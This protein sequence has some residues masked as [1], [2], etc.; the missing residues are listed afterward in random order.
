VSTEG[1]KEKQLI[2]RLETKIGLFTVISLVILISGLLWLDGRQLLD[3][4]YQLEVAFTHV[5]GLRPGAPVQMSGVD[6][7][8][9]GRVTFTSEGQVLVVLNLTPAV[10]IKT[11]ALVTINTAG[12]LGE[13]II[14][15][16]PGAGPEKIQPGARLQ[17]K[18]PF[19]T[20]DLFR[21][22]GEV[23]ASLKRITTT[24]D[25]FLTDRALLDRLAQTTTDL[26]T[27]SGNLAAFSSQLAATDLD[28]L[29]SAIKTITA[30][31]ATINFDGI[32]SLLAAAADLPAFLDRLNAMVS[33]FDPF[34]QELYR[35][36][37]EL[38]A[39]GRTAAAVNH[40]LSALEPTADNLARLSAQ[41]SEGDPNLADLMTATEETLT[42]VRMMTTGLQQLVGEVA[43]EDRTGLF[44]S[45]MEKAGRVLNLA[46]DFLKTYD[47]LN[48]SNQFSLSVTP[49]DWGFDYQAKLA[50]NRHRFLLFGWE[51]LGDRN[52]F[53]LQYGL[54]QDPWRFRLGILHNWL[55]LGLNY[56]HRNFSL[57]ADLW[58]PN[59]PVLDVYTEYRLE[60]FSL[61]VGLR[62][63]ASPARQWYTSLGWVF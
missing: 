53:S 52:R 24:L 46:D 50:W 33:A 60:P 15:I 47:H 12:L 39:D 19:S 43:P 30:R 13:K 38:R 36:L 4:A 41:L 16:I 26:E 20:E 57:Q 21:E 59:Q 14:E 40:I 22:T 35:F 56:N 3:R 51:D 29:L 8:R 10:T 2:S 49:D 25:Q 44:T 32:N 37:T 55:G 27:I 48:L 23:I 28:G 61:K 34:Q 54:H 9:V 11:G 7:G 1:G 17:G 18:E 5:G 31:L 62:N 6:I 42:S 63:I 58:Q 45:S